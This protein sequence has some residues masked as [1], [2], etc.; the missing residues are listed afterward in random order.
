MH[1]QLDHNLEVLC[2]RLFVMPPLTAVERNQ[3]HEQAQPLHPLSS[4][5]PGT[6][7]AHHQI[8]APTLSLSTTN[9]WDPH[10]VCVDCTLKLQVGLHKQGQTSINIRA[11]KRGTKEKEYLLNQTKM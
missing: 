9:Y 3:D 11:Y 1:G 2:P 7:P 5:S 8:V 10:V 6:M 4:A